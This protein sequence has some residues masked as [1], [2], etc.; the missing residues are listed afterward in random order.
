MF[1]VCGAATN[2]DMI[3]KSHDVKRAPRTQGLRIPAGL[4]ARAEELIAMTDAFC[5]AHLDDE[6]AELCRALIGKLARK[7]R[8]PIATGRLSIWAGAVLHAIGDV[9]FLFDSSQRPHM[10]AG[11][12]SELLGLSKGTV[13]NKSRSIR[14]LL[15]LYPMHPEFS[16]REV[17]NENPLTWMVELNGLAVDVRSLP[18]ELQRQAHEQGL[19]PAFPPPA[20]RDVADGRSGWTPAAGR[21]AGDADQGD[22]AKMSGY[23]ELEVSLLHIEPRIWRRFLIRPSATFLD[24][25]RAIQSAFGWENAHLFEFRRTGRQRVV[26]ATAP[27]EDLW[28]DVDEP[29]ADEVLLGEYFPPLGSARACQYEYDFGDNWEHKVRLRKRHTDDQPFERRLLGGA[30]A[31]P[32]EDCG[33]V[34]GYEFTVEIGESE[35]A[36]QRALEMGYDEEHVDYLRCWDPDAFDLDAFKARFDR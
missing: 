12:V 15:D 17:A 19:V 2:E 18:V 34:P 14:L 9:N 13:A 11:R 5:A 33:S 35:E 23:L 3:M 31:C 1:T 16:R 21:Q 10:K 27:K 6:Y 22:V 30:R 4:R 26:V 29:E 8:S 20:R 28:D 7:Q 36:R 24:L 32:L 25:H